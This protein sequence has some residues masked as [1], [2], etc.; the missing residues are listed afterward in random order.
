M[1][2][3]DGGEELGEGLVGGRQEV[4]VSKATAFGSDYIDSVDGS[5]NSGEEPMQIVFRHAPSQSPYEYS[6]LSS[7]FLFHHLQISAFSLSLPL[8][9]LLLYLVGFFNLGL[10][11]AGPI[12]IL[13]Y[14]KEYTYIYE[15]AKGS[16]PRLLGGDACEERTVQILSAWQVLSLSLSRLLSLSLTMT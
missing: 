16:S 9:L 1:K 8:P 15:K 3:T 11:Q 10:S 13:Y 4:D 5:S 12:S 2:E 14:K 6:L 7:L